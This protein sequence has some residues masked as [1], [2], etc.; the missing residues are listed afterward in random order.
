MKAH[1]ALFIAALLLATTVSA[2]DRAQFNERDRQVTNDWYRQH[3]RHAPKGLRAQDRL[4][5][6]EEARLQRGRPLPE[7]LRRRTY[8]MPR[9]L[10]R[11]LAAPPRHH[12]YVAVG[13]HVALVDSRTHEVRDVIHVHEQD[14]RDDR[15]H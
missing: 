2:Q 15:R 13:G 14:T 6:E 11:Q 9:D 7:D 8:S 12:R 5:P 1:H 4:S 10:E 3:Q